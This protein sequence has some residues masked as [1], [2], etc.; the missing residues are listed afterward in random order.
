MDAMRLLIAA[1]LADTL[2]RPATDQEIDTA[3]LEMD[4]M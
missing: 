3:I 1:E 2:G 4:T